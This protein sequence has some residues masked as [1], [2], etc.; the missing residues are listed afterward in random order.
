MNK[1]QTF[2][3]GFISAFSLMPSTRVHLS[4]E[5]QP[6][7]YVAEAWKMTGEHLSNALGEANRP[8]SK[9]QI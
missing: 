9:S 6:V 8:N 2:F 5:K 3:K 1:T 4:E 7:D